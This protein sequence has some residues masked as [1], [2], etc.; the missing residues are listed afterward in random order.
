MMEERAQV[1]MSRLV[2][3]REELGLSQAEL[4]ARTGLAQSAIA[5]FEMQRVMP[6]LDTVLNIAGALGLEV[7]LVWR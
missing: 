7:E 1:L 2:A 6:R 3:R 4:A 5:R